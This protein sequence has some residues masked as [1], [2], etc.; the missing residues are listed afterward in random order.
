[1]LVHDEVW[2]GGGKYKCIETKISSS[3]VKTVV[4]QGINEL[5]S[6]EVAPGIHLDT[7]S[8]WSAGEQV[9]EQLYIC[10]HA[11][12]CLNDDDCPHR[13]KHKKKGE[14]CDVGCGYY[15]GIHGATCIPYK[16]E[17]PEPKTKR[18]AVIWFGEVPADYVRG[19][20]EITRD[21]REG[22]EFID[23]DL[24]TEG[25]G[26]LVD[27][28]SYKIYKV[29]DPPTPEPKETVEDVLKRMPN[30]THY[31]DPISGASNLR[32]YYND[33]KSCFKDLKAAQERQGCP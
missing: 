23:G 3:G 12:N 30:P 19:V 26:G 2:I 17:N 1:M 11:K 29:I 33:M 22:V 27:G 28:G 5:D 10:D 15:R 9:E 25:F 7:S 8:E 31:Q 18:V 24:V 21:Q 4:L 14:R 16:E 13:E 20:I 32:G 6:T